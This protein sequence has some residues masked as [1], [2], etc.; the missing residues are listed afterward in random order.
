M[1]KS[2][3]CK[4]SGSI[5]LWRYAERDRNYPGWHFSADYAGSD[6]LVALLD[7]LVGN[8]AGEHRT[9]ALSVPGPSVLPD[10][11]R[12]GGW[13]S[14]SKMRIAISANPNT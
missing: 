14:T 8:L 9:I 5:S 6:S 1:R 10:Q 2:G 13:V 12:S 7:A 3:S 11:Y 4:Q